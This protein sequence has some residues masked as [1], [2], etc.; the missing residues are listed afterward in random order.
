MHIYKNKYLYKNV[1]SAKKSSKR[2]CKDIT[3]EERMPLSL[4]VW[5]E[6]AARPLQWQKSIEAQVPPITWQVFV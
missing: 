1:H 2:E 5:R 3:N 4:S 6:L